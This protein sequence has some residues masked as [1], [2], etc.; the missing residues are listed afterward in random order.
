MRGLI[1]P[2]SAAILP[3]SYLLAE[4]YP[5]TTGYN[6]IDKRS[7]ARQHARTAFRRLTL[8]ESLFFVVA[9]AALIFISRASLREPKSHGF[10]RFFAWELVLMLVVSNMDGWY[11]A[12]PSLDQ[13][14]CSAL[15]WL[16]LFLA[17]VSHLSL[18]QFGQEDDNLNDIPLLEFEK[19]T[20]LVTR[21]IYRFIRHPMYGPLIFL[22]WGLYFKRMSWLSGS[23][24]L[25]ACVFLINW[26][27]R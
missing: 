10:Y 1:L 20:V 23:I 8:L 3:S 24:A 13:S 26:H 12:P 6:H 5:R 9:S 25:V 19:T 16:S 17:V 4:Q 15:M 21:G 2:L 7:A 14:I 27:L 22:D 11:D 18:R